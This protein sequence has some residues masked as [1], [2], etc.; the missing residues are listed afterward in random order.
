MSLYT[1]LETTIIVL[2]G[3]ISAYHVMKMLMPRAVGRA[4]AS[5]AL[6]LGRGA[7]AA[8][9][10]RALAVKVRGDTAHAAACDAGCGSGCSTCSIALQTRRSMPADEQATR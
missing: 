6:R 5:L 2:V 10:R 8:S 7:D 9:R 3:V 1:F 4:R